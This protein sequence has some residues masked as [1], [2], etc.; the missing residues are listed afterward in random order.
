MPSTFTIREKLSIDTAYMKLISD[1]NTTHTTA[2]AAYN[3][4]QQS[5]NYSRW[6]QSFQCPPT[7][8]SDVLPPY[9]AYMKLTRVQARSEAPKYGLHSHVLLTTHS[10]E[11]LPGFCSSTQTYFLMMISQ[12]VLQRMVA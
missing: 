9:T 7:A 8:A 4:I 10:L 5:E 12:R 6:N 1:S 3:L 2:A 11:L